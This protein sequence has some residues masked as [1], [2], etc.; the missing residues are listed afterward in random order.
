[1]NATLQ[2]PRA[3]VTIGLST[4]S[5]TIDVVHGLRVCIYTKDHEPPHVHVLN[6]DGEMRIDLLELSVSRA[7]GRMTAVAERA[8][9]RLVR[10]NQMRYLREW[11]RIHPQLDESA[12]T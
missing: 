10:K 9:V 2:N 1:M 7:G 8:A 3:W 4:L 12:R 5:P 6:H 11:N